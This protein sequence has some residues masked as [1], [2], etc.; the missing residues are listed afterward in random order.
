[1]GH[2]HGLVNQGLVVT[3]GLAT[4]AS[5]SAVVINSQM[6]ATTATFLMKRLR[7]FLQLIGRTTADDG[8]IIIGAA[9]G[10]ATVS[11]IEAAMVELNPTGPSSITDMLTEDTAWVIYRNT[12]IPMVIKGDQTFAQTEHSNWINFGGRN[13]I[14]APEGSGFQLF[15]YNSGPGALTTGSSMQGHFDVQG[16]WLRD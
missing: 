16:V 2:G 4:L 15:A 5:R 8:P 14:P 12:L 13:G 3:Q 9:H 11:E 10:D 6:T 7:Y 1:M